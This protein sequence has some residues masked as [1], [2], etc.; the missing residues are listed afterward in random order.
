VAAAIQA[1]AG[2]SFRCDLAGKKRN[3]KAKKG[4]SK[5]NCFTHPFLCL[6]AISLV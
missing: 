3:A 5:A 1:I 4:M 6:Q 2:L